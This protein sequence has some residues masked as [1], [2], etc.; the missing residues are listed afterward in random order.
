MYCP[1]IEANNGRRDDKRLPDLAVCMLQAICVYFVCC[2]N[3]S[4]SLCLNNLCW[5]TVKN[6]CCHED[7]VLLGN[8]R[9]KHFCCVSS[10]KVVFFL[11]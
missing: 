3:D 2:E 1:P 7:N 9:Y 4:K 11:K 10:A 6:A 5:H 8:R